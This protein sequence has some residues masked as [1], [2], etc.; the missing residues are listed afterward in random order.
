MSS[1]PYR[2]ASYIVDAFHASTQPPQSRIRALRRRCI[3]THAAMDSITPY[4][5]R[6]SCPALQARRLACCAIDAACRTSPLRTPPYWAR[7]STSR[8]PIARPC[9]DIHAPTAPRRCAPWPPP[10]R[11]LNDSRHRS[12]STCAAMPVPMRQTQGHATSQSPQ[13]P[14]STSRRRMEQ[15]CSRSCFH[16]CAS[17]IVEM[18]SYGGGAWVRTLGLALRPSPFLAAATPSFWSCKTCPNVLT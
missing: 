10:C 15:A 8:H 7:D 17:T 16:L 13:R 4:A 9:G 12:G 18:D 3:H 11:C 2:A 5:V 14:A 6:P 1:R